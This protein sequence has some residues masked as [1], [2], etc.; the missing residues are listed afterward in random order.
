[1]D[2]ETKDLTRRPMSEINVTPFVDVMLV[3]LVI[4]MITAPVMKQGLDINLPQTKNTKTLSEAEVIKLVIKSSGAVYMGKQVIPMAR[5]GHK[6]KGLLKGQAD[7]KVHIEAD[8]RVP[9]GKV[10]QVMAEAKA[11]GVSSVGLITLPE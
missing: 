5:L 4:F 9:Y 3:L 1:M 11:A 6:L 10:A 2:F 7:N 8:T